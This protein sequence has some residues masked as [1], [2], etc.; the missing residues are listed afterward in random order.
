MKRFVHIWNK[1]KRVGLYD[2]E[3]ITDFREVMLINVLMASIPLVMI[4]YIPTEIFFNGLEMIPASLI[5]M[6]LFTFPLYFNYKR[7]FTFSKYFLFI[8]VCMF[9]LVMG[10]L[11]GRKINNHVSLLPA[12]LF[13]MVIFRKTYQRI[14]ASCFVAFVY[15][16]HVYLPTIIEPTFVLPDEQYRTFTIIFYFVAM[17]LTFLVGFYFVNMNQDYEKII[18]HQKDS[19]EERNKEITD[20]INYAKR[21]QT[22]LLPSDHF[23]ETE[24]ENH[25]VLYLPKD[26]VAGDFYWMETVE[27]NGK[28][29]LLI[30]VA[31][32][33]GH[34]VPGAMVSVICHNALN[35]C[36]REFEITD[37]GMILNKTRELVV[38]EFEKSHEDVKD[39]MDISLLKF[40]ISDS[41]FSNC[42]WA[43]ANNPLWILRNKEMLEIK[44]DKQPI[45]KYA[46]STPFT[47]HEIEIQKGDTVYLFSDGYADQFGGDKNKKLKSSVFKQLLMD[48]GTYDL[49]KQKQEL[50]VY[51]EKWRG[52]YEQ[53]D[54]ICVIGI[55]F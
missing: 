38:A 10:I 9:I 6:V 20:S 45:G 1:I 27:S 44:G 24:L 13:G 29:S 15:C 23:L 5:M 49:K 36:V 50:H 48:N 51:F 43:G 22:A 12:L 35:R 40:E 18:L 4:V 16:M 30:A 7:W 28:K 42:R 19:L 41:K 2:H 8:V 55:K 52:N 33:T 54:D 46:N 17:V 37:P 39:G 14:I 31:D 34:G 47:T 32:C 53:N 25:F 21:I 11:V 26:I 3:G